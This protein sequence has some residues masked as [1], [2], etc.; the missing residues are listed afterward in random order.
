MTTFAE[1]R[2]RNIALGVWGA[3]GG[4]GAAA[5]VLLGGSSPTLLGVDLLR[6]HPG[7]P[8][9]GRARACAAE[10]ESRHAREVVRRSARCSSS[11]LTAPCSRSRRGTS[12]AGPAARSASSRLRGAPRRLRRLGEPRRRAADALRPAHEDRARRQRLRLHLGTALFSMF[13]ILTLYMQQVLGYSADGSAR[14]PRRR[15]H[16]DHLGERRRGDGQPGRCP[17]AD[18]R[19]DGAARARDDPVRADPVDGSYAAD[20]LPGLI[21]ALGMAL[22][23]VPISIAALAGVSQAEAGIASA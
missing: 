8:G 6:Q 2:E 22:C 23:F 4:F 16:L 19:R 21:V 12:G 15:G 9:R 18:R 17:A 1:G 14:V 13:L 7:R 5:G 10:G 3:V 11:G 20:L